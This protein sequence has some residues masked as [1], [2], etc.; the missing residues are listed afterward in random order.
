MKKENATIGIIQRSSIDIIK[1]LK[2]NTFNSSESKLFLLNYIL[3]DEE[4]SN[5]EYINISLGTSIQQ[6]SLKSIQVIQLEGILE[7]E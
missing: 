1:P 6:L 4:F 3:M 7:Y 5:F 2:M